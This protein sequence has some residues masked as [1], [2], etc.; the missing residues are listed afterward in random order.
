MSQNDS[1][2][3]KENEICILDFKKVHAAKDYP[4]FVRELATRVQKDGFHP[5]GDWIQNLAILDL[6]S[7]Q[8]ALEVLTKGP[9]KILASEGDEIRSIAGAGCVLCDLLAVAEGLEVSHNPS[10]MMSRISSLA[11]IA[12]L[13]SLKRKGVGLK[14]YY[15]NMSLG[16]NSDK[17]LA[18]FIDGSPYG[19]DINDGFLG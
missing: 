2:D 4:A 14:L 18:E 8:T 1:R 6:M 15:E 12:A 17:P 19:P 10:D 13:E 11:F 9:K 5:V 7:L 3:L 16:G